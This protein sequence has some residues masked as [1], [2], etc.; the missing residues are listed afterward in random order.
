MKKFKHK[1]TGI[2]V[3]ED[4]HQYL[5]TCM[6]IPKE[7]VENSNDWEE[8]VEKDYEIL[9]LK[10]GQIYYRGKN[11]HN[12][13]CYYTDLKDKH[14][15]GFIL[16]QTFENNLLPGVTIHSVRRLLDGEIFQIGDTINIGGKNRVIEAFK[17]VDNNLYIITDSGKDMWSHIENWKKAKQALFKTEDNIDIFEGDEFYTVFIEKIGSTEPFTLCKLIGNKS[18]RRPFG[19]VLDFSTKEAAEE[20]I[21]WNKPYLSYLDVYLTIQRTSVNYEIKHFLCDKIKALVKSKL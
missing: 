14:N 5:G 2:I 6:S 11:E 13:I 15:S 4:S 10:Y 7:I 3:N 20:Y 19:A 16:E 21:L 17:S 9:S 8:I 12:Q 18:I 1:K